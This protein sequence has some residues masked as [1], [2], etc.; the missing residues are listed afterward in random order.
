MPKTHYDKS[1]VLVTGGCGFIGSHLVRKLVALGAHVTVVDDLSNGSLENIA[2]V[3]SHVRLIRASIEDRCVCQ[4]ALRGHASVFHM[5]ARIYVAESLEKPDLYHDVNVTGTFNILEAARHN[6]VARVVFSSSAAVYGNVNHTCNE[7]VTTQPVSPYGFSKVMAE[8]LCLQYARVYGLETVILRYFNVF[9]PGQNT[10]NSCAPVV[11]LF[12]NKME[13]NEPL[14]IFGDGLQT[15]DFI[16]VG[17]VVHANLILGCARDVA[18]RIFNIASGQ[19]TSLLELVD[20][21]KKRFPHYDAPV[22]FAPERPGELRHSRADV[23]KYHDLFRKFNS[24][25]TPPMLSGH[26]SSNF[27]TLLESS[28]PDDPS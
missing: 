28:V 12:S 26:A 8:Q 6:K 19:E 23:T 17:D 20:L 11:A 27:E 7:E 13:H 3:A 2:P 10:N 24:R 18:G 16:H 4:E 22:I 14:T 21:L 1:H 9:G 5:A 25:E 15:R